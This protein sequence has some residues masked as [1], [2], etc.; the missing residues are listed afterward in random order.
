MINRGP[1]FLAVVWFGSSPIPY[2][3]L[4]SERY[5]SLSVF[6][7]GEWRGGIG[8]ESNDSIIRP[9]ESPVLYKSFILSALLPLFSDMFIVYL[10]N[11]LCSYFISFVSGRLFGNALP[12]I[13]NNE[14][15][16]VDNFTNLW[17]HGYPPPPSLFE[18]D[19][20]DNYGS[21][22]AWYTNTC[23]HS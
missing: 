17:I 6:L 20:I 10:S 4:P 23:T 13:M 15:C 7:T 9:R 5:F 14:G 22:C 19:K 18:W 11:N 8:E 2:P 12:E 16:R 3:L 1:G 21:I